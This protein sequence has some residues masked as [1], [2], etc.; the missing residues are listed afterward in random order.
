MGL[1][2]KQ[3]RD[4]KAGPKPR[5][6]R[7]DDPAGLALRIGASGRRSWVL[8]YRAADGRK[9]RW[10]IGTAEAFNLDQ[11]RQVA[12]EAQRGL[13]KGVDPLEVKASRKA[14]ATVNDLLDR[15]VSEHMPKR[16]ELGRMKP[17]T[18]SEYKRQA[19]RLL[20]PAL[21]KLTVED[22]QTVHIERMVR[23][24]RP[25]MRNR[26]LALASK[27]FRLAEDWKLRPQHTNP[28]RGVE[29]ASEKERL[30]VLSADEL[31]AF[32]KALNE[33]AGTN[34]SAILAIKLAALTGLRIG[35]VRSIRWDAMDMQSGRLELADTKTGERTHTLPAPALALIAEAPRIG[36]YLIAG[37]Y[38][39]APLDYRVIQRVFSRVCELAEI[40]G[41]KL[42]DLR[43]TAM[44]AAARRGASVP[45]LQDLLGHKT[46][47][48]A[49]RYVKMGGDE[50]D[51]LREAIGAEAAALM[52]G[53]PAASVARLRKDG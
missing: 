19:E 46:A 41:A 29:R 22:V 16:L 10:T 36:P 40:E 24:L 9:R 4:A 53:T 5:Y 32:G 51:Q 44:T 45:L 39:R 33:I 21:G 25:V 3:V 7:D 47:A 11:A 14:R 37:R 27:V 8:D 6:L 50:A 52:G 13:A 26:V 15:F 1:T 42:H 38:D 12:K 2:A 18:V 31:R 30:R 35:E 34:P 28:T 17:R 48:M 49:M 20:R 23:D 43:R